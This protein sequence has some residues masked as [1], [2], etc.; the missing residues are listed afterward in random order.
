MK[1]IGPRTHTLLEILY[2][3]IL[4]VGNLK[5]KKLSFLTQTQK[6]QKTENAKLVFTFDKVK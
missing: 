5:I 6:K 1:K 3:A 2:S 4:K